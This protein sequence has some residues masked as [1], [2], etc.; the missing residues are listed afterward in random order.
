MASHHGAI[1]KMRMTS[2]RTQQYSEQI[3]VRKP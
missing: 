3:L 2:A 1:A